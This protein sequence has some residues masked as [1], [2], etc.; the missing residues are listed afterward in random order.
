[1]F[2]CC[3]QDVVRNLH[4]EHWRNLDD[5]LY[6]NW[7]ISMGEISYFPSNSFMTLVYFFKKVINEG[8]YTCTNTI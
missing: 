2:G 7:E 8:L 5:I 6:M 4:T 1:M 3:R